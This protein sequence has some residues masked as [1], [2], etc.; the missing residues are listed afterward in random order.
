MSFSK[1]S[2]TILFLFFFLLSAFSSSFAQEKSFQ[3]AV[4]GDRTGGHKPGIFPE[5]VEEVNLLNPDIV[6]TVG[7]FIEGYTIDTTVL[8][9]EWDGFLGIMGKL[10]AP[11]YFVP[12]NHDITY[13]EC[14]PVYKKRVGEPYY[15]FDYKNVHFVILD[16]SRVEKSEDVPEKQISWLVSDLE[17]NKEKENIYVF[18]HK[19]LWIKS[20]KEKKSDKLHQIFK[21]YGV[22]AV[23]SGHYHHYFSG[24]ID[25]I[26]YICVGSSGGAMDINSEN[27]GFFYHY[28][29]C[30]VDGDKL[31][32]ALVK[33]GSV[34]DVDFVTIEDELVIDALI[35]EEKLIN[36]TPLFIRE[37]VEGWSGPSFLNITNIDTSILE[38]TV[39]WE[40]SDN[41]TITPTFFPIEIAPSNT[42]KLEFQFQLKGHIFPLPQ[43]RFKYSFGDNKTY[44]YQNP[45][46]VKREA[47]CNKIRKS[48]KVDGKVEKKEWSDFVPIQQ[49][50]SPEGGATIVEPTKFYFGYDKNNLYLAVFC[51]ESEKEKLLAR[52]EKQD[53]AVYAEDCVGYFFCPDT[54]KKTVY[55][56][57]FNPKG[58]VFDQLIKIFGDDMDVKREWDGEY[59]VATQI[60]DDFWSIE[61]KISFSVLKTK[62]EK[63]DIWQVNFR[64]KQKRLDS[65]S[66][67]IVPISY[68]PK[69]YGFL[70]FE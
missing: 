35:Y 8:N 68:E 66:D 3:F 62:P 67:W 14:E 47:L 46:L 57:Y 5:A 31:D 26:R 7:D 27:L 48:I 17:K 49:F 39:R 16:V 21:E 11:Y 51:E 12:G 33:L 44:D 6:M 53:G 60:G 4:L 59:E 61:V 2:F 42:E 50:G 45:I 25:G 1:I 41:W 58:T 29:W 56:I 30:T 10:E 55:Q 15:S 23:F 9:Q 54:V 40:F 20:V 70:K 69:Y 38:D 13:D 34:K 18:Y 22:D 64:R 65:S 24:D 28:L 19:P 63:G 43:C 37:E 52:A 32:V 36:S